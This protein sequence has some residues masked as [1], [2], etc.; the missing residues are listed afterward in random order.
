MEFLS[1]I[2]NPLDTC[3]RCVSLQM[4]V[5]STR[6]SST[7][8]GM[9]CDIYSSTEVLPV[10]VV[11]TYL[12]VLASLRTQIERG[13]ATA[14]MGSKQTFALNIWHTR[15]HPIATSALVRLATLRNGIVYWLI[16][17]AQCRAVDRHRLIWWISLHTRIGLMNGVAPGI[18]FDGPICLQR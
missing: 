17:C 18:H 7:V 10:H 8:K 6:I 13:V 14:A 1:T 11:D 12:A 3:P 16:R 9:V 15:E 2:P 5:P 4:P